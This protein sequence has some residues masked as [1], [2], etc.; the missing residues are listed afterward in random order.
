VL[1]SIQMIDSRACFGHTADEV[2]EEGRCTL[3]VNTVTIELRDPCANVHE[4]DLI[5]EMRAVACSRHRCQHG[6][7]E[8]R[9][10]EGLLLRVQCFEL[11]TGPNDVLQ[12]R[13]RG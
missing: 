9:H 7:D 10:V 11:E 1:S 13:D 6:E 4:G 8:L 3:L 2:V 12:P 5:D